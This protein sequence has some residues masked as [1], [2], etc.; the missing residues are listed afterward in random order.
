[1]HRCHAYPT[2]YAAGARAISRCVT[3]LSPSGDVIAVE[4]AVP[5]GCSSAYALVSL[6]E[7]SSPRR[8][9]SRIDQRFGCTFGPDGVRAEAAR[10]G[11]AGIML[12]VLRTGSIAH[13]DLMRVIQ[14]PHPD[15]SVAKTAALLYG[16]PTACMMYASRDVK[17]NEW[18]GTRD[19][20]HRVQSLHCPASSAPSSTQFSASCAAAAC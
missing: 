16:H 12:R 20:L 8:P 14:R 15:W 2:L 13:G 1:M 7:I 4:R 19:E 11:S 17:L 9:C 18:M 3:R 6:L 10:T 5:Q